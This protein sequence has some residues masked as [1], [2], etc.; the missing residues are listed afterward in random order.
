MS[1]APALLLLLGAALPAQGSVEVRVRFAADA[2][3]NGPAGL[4]WLRTERLPRLP[5][6]P[7][8]LSP[9]DAFELDLATSGNTVRTSAPPPGDAYLAGEV[10]LPGWGSLLL[11]CDRAG[12]EDWFAPDR[13]LPPELF[14]L[15]GNAAAAAGVPC[16]VDVGALAGHLTTILTDAP[17]ADLLTA[18][19][20]MCGEVTLQWWRDAAGVRVR[21]RSGGGLLLPAAIAWLA[22]QPPTA[23]PEQWFAL[24]RQQG[25]GRWPLRAFVSRDGFRA[26]A[27]RQLALAPAAVGTLGALLH[28]DPVTR[29]AA[30]DTL[31]RQG[32][33][34]ALP[35][36]VRAADPGQ[37]AT[38]A[39]A[40]L[41]VD[42]LWPGA[43][44]A[45]RADVHRALVHNPIAD[46]R[47]AVRAAAAPAADWRRPLVLTLAVT[48]LVLL[49]LLRRERRRAA[50][51]AAADCW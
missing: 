11:R 31:V 30:M 50:A 2:N 34:G 38:V 51:A 13:P 43:G 37:P 35:G 27:A 8:G 21:G 14:A 1:R 18:G 9:R 19:A 46:L 33:A 20:A 29:L 47:A 28:A 42:Q 24:P 6:W 49:V 16:T 25:P 15:V 23:R 48:A 10:V 44:P 17:G 26:E 32:D 41:A 5:G 7:A 3:E 40:R 12:I 39:M 45:T 4:V 22:A 36:I